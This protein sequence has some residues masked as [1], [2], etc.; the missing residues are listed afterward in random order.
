[1]LSFFISYSLPIFLFFFCWFIYIY[2]SYMQNQFFFFL[3]YHFS[4]H[5]TNPDQEQVTASQVFSTHYSHWPQHYCSHNWFNYHFWWYMQYLLQDD[6]LVKILTIPIHGYFMMV[7]PKRVVILTVGKNGLLAVVKEVINGEGGVG[8]DVTNDNAD[9]GSGNGNPWGW[10][11]CFRWC[12]ILLFPQKLLL[13][14]HFCSYFSSYSR[15]LP[16]THLN[17]WFAVLAKPKITLSH[18]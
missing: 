5:H 14:S 11:W 6:N 1:M 18:R 17:M 9:E 2:F 15:T 4:L 13:S 12:L 7:I 16:N 8:N 10:Y 3:L